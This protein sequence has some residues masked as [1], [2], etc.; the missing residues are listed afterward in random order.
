V[1]SDSVNEYQVLINIRHTD[2][3]PY[4]NLWLFV[5]LQRDSILLRRDTIEAQMANERGEWQG[6]GI[7]QYALP[8][9]YLEGQTLTQGE[10]T[11]SIQQ[12]MRT[13]KL[14]GITEVGVRI[15]VS[16]LR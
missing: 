4:Q 6:Q 2:R 3:Y 15:E 12:G 14:P 1:L 9:L 5:D 16:E 7:S 8:L 11:V 13:E 10:Y